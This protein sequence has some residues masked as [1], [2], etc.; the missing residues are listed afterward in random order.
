MKIKLV[1]L[2]GLILFQSCY[3]YKELELRHEGLEL[4]ER[5]K[6]NHTAYGRLKKGKI[7]QMSDTTITYKLNN[8]RIDELRMEEIK[9]IK[10]GKFSLGKTI[11]LPVSIT[12]VVLG[13]SWL[14]WNS[15]SF[16]FGY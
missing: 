3:S 15:S 2:G 7:I 13:A 5:Y 8:G 14:A 11:A 10:K 6:L 4:G 12:G 16:S 9:Q 1:L